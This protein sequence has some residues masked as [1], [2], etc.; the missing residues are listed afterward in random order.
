MAF[1]VG[2]LTQWVN[3]NSQ[4]LLTKAV[5]QAETIPY[6]TVIPGVKYKERL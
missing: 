2:A 4:E 6:I 5:L 3:D 1:N